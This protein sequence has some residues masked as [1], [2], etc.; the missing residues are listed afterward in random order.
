MLPF[1]SAPNHFLQIIF[2]VFY[3][4]DKEHKEKKNIPIS[5]ELQMIHSDVQTKDNTFVNADLL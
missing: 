2:S 4:C 1:L 3:L 5:L